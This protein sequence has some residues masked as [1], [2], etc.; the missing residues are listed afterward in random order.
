MFP[1]GPTGIFMQQHHYQAVPQNTACTLLP[2]TACISRKSAYRATNS[3]NLDNYESYILRSSKLRHSDCSSNQI[4]KSFD[5]INENTTLSEFTRRQDNRSASLILLADP[6]TNKSLSWAWGATGEQEW[7]PA[8]TTGVDWKSLVIP[9]CLPVTTDFYP[10]NRSLINDYVESEYTLLPDVQ[11]PNFDQNDN[12]ASQVFQELICQRLQQ[13][14]Q[15]I[16]FS[17]EG[18]INSNIISPTNEKHDKTLSI[19]RI[20]HRLKLD[21]SILNIKTYRPRHPYPTTKIH[22]CYRFRGQDNNT[23]G[24]S[25]ADFISE[26]LENYNW[27]HLDNYICTKGEPEFSLKSGLKYWRVRILLLPKKE[28]I[29]RRIIENFLISHSPDYACESYTMLDLEERLQLHDGLLRFAEIINRIRK[30]Q[31]KQKSILLNLHR[32]QDIKRLY[33]SPKQNKH[34]GSIEGDKLR[35]KGSKSRDDVDG[36]I[37]TV[38]SAEFDS[39]NVEE[40]FEPKKLS[41][42]TPIRV[43]LDYLKNSKY[44]FFN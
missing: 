14:F 31:S 39:A 11:S 8:I 43:I 23:Y 40:T 42:N 35:L 7:T 37:L 25:W 6:H 41:S 24:V 27:N 22:Y 3:E 33:S 19:G 21:N 16:L 26:K 29:T 2:A 30:N 38:A 34:S 20:F 1:L 17:K 9:A 12:L 4:N 13:G 10:D 18:A 28:A 32:I 5:M 44:L 36:N 15:I